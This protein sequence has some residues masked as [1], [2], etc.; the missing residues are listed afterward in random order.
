VIEHSVPYANLEDVSS[1]QREETL[2]IDH[3]TE[4]VGNNLSSRIKRPKM[5]APTS[6]IVFHLSKVNRAD[7]A[8]S[9]ARLRMVTVPCISCREGESA[10]LCK[11]IG[12]DGE[13]ASKARLIGKVSSHYLAGKGHYKPDPSRPLSRQSNKAPK[14]KPLE[15]PRSRRSGS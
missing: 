7:T 2:P 6:E 3:E 4:K 14:S 13:G 12:Y 1:R 11:R 9:K 5:P 15:H 8:F 10:R